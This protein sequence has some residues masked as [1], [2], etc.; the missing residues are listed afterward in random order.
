[1]CLPVH[2]CVQQVW[3]AQVAWKGGLGGGGE[4]DAGRWRGG[5][6]AA[7][8]GPPACC[9]P[10]SQDTNPP[11]SPFTPHPHP[12]KSTAYQNPSCQNSPSARHQPSCTHLRQC[13]Q[14]LQPPLLCRGQ[15][16]PHQLPR[17]VHAAPPQRQHSSVVQHARRHAARRA[18]PIGQAVAV[19][20]G[21]V[22][23]LLAVQLDGLVVVGQGGCRDRGAGRG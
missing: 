10:S 2:V 3:H 22:G 5:L 23:G 17:F 1:M 7:G 11:S 6:V 20:G 13:S 16:L 12:R 15:R 18:V 8:H 4:Y 19:G 9:S 21:R 14:L